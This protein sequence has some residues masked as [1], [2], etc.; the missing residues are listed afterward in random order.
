MSRPPHNSPFSDSPASFAPLG[1][2]RGRLFTHGLRRGLYSCAAS[3]HC[4]SLLHFL[5]ASKVAIDSRDAL[6]IVAGMAALR[7]LHGRVARH[8]TR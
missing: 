2:A 5:F 8:Q 3:R 1:L 6:S 4:G 7:N